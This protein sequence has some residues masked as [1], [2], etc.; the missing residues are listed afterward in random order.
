MKKVEEVSA[1]EVLEQ[2]EISDIGSMSYL[3][4]HK[5]TGA[6]VAL[7]SNDDENKVF[8]IGFRT[9][10]KDSTGVA[11]ILE[12][13]VLCGSREFPVKDPFVELVKGS[14][15]TFLNAM[16][17]PDKTLYPVASCNDKD[18]Q[19]LMHVY[20]DAVFYPNIYRKEA[21]FRQEGWHY[22]LDEE[23]GE[24]AYNGVVYNEMKGAFSSPDEVLLREITNALYPHTTYGCESGGDPDVI[25]EL[26]Y[27]Q[28]LKFHQTYYHPSNSYIYLYGDMDMAEKLEF[29]DEHYLSAFQALEVD[30]QVTAEP[31]FTQPV[32]RVREYPLNEGEDIEENTILSW[33][34]SVGDSLD[35]ELYVALQ[36]LDYALCSAP[37][38]PLKQALV[39]R[40]LG[41]DVYSIYENGMKQPFFSIVSKDIPLDREQDFLATIREMLTDIAEKGFDEK[42]LLAGINYYEFKYREADFG[43][44]PKGLMYG[45]QILDS[46]L[47]DDSLPFIHIEANATFALLREKVKKGYFEG[48]VRKYLLENPHASTVLLKPVVGLG[49]RKEE[50]LRRKLKERRSKM[51]QDELQQIRDTF[52][53]LNDFRDT[54]DRPKD[55]EKL[56]HLSVSDIKKEAAPLV[57]RQIRLGDTP[58]L[59]HKL[60]TNGIG[61]LRLIFICREVPGEY[62]PYIEVLKGCLALLNTA[63]Y[64]YGDLFNETNLYTGGIAAVNNVYEQ[65]SNPDQY[66][67]TL[68]LKTKVFYRNLEKALELMEEILLTSDFSDTKRLYEILAEGKSRMQASMTSSGHVVAMVRAGSYCSRS[69][70]AAEMI[71]GIS[72]YRLLTHLEE[73]FEEQKEQLV[74]KLLLLSRMIFRPENLM[75]DFIGDEEMLERLETPVARLREKLY[76]VPVEKAF[77]EPAVERKNEGF[78]TSGQVQYVCR[79]GNFRHRGLPYRGSLKVLKVMME[80]EYL[81]VNVR[82]KGGAY[83]CMCGFDKSGDCYFVSYRDPN[84]GKTVEVYEKASEF[85]RSFDADGRVMAQ[86]IIGAVSVLD[87]PMNPAAKGLKSLTAYMTGITDELLQEERDQVLNATPEDI[88]SLAEYIDVFMGEDCLCVVGNAQKIKGEQSLFGSVENLF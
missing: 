43:S 42:A 75:V 32:R 4:R 13:S 36:V 40:G 82:V 23:S 87:K 18:F 37:G 55:L 20:L 76:T 12:H 64:S 65:I 9:T 71:G 19:N 70:A 83:G 59:Y 3:L 49:E 48:L 68:E 61:Y 31:A 45:L 88:R 17:Y 44:T 52:R 27:E 78:M 6:R 80:Y 56:P 25:P 2:R 63:N 79:S 72:L 26:T 50:E 47:Y 57:N 7:L 5:K 8:Y 85:V 29:I 39:D 77:Y 1:Y 46:W 24:L 53:A 33:N 62:F 30:S 54:P 69:G 66:T 41:K 34:L 58:G 22:E 60:A 15:N 28:F 35:R 38:A 14:L 10:P 84:L 21:I 11:H 74:E 67:V 81:W 73:N 86:Y 51:T 16:T